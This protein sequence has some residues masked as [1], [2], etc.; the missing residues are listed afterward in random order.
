MTTID[1][2]QLYMLVRA[3]QGNTL[4][5]IGVTVHW[6]PAGAYG[7]DT[8]GHHWYEETCLSGD[9]EKDGIITQFNCI[10]IPIP[11]WFESR[12]ERQVRISF[13]HPHGWGMKLDY[14]L[15][16]FGPRDCTFEEALNLIKGET[17]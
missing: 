9:P 16:I 6:V 5:A 17:K 11:K 10:K 7:P 2:D 3:A 15:P 13:P 14:L 1:T 12:D 8:P 4:G